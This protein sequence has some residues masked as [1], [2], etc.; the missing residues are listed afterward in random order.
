MKL[1]EQSNTEN[2]LSGHLAEHPNVYLASLW[3]TLPRSSFNT[4]SAVN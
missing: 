3:L 1:Y 4:Y 2:H